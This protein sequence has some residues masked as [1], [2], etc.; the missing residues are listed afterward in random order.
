LALS[1]CE[2]VTLCTFTTV[3]VPADVCPD[4]SAATAASAASVLNDAVSFGA[5]GYGAFAE[6]LSMRK[7]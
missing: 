1:T 7:F 3:H 5:G 6:W 4:K 2:S